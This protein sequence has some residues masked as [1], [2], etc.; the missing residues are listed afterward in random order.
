MS[1]TAALDLLKSGT[2]V[3]LVLTDHAM[4][5]MTGVDL[6]RHIRALRPEMAIIL[7]TGYAEL[8]ANADSSLLRLAKPY[9][10]EEMLAAIYRQMQ[11]SQPASN[12]VPFDAI[13][14]A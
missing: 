7:A 6:A 13:R 11:V 3:D 9:T 5:G 12:I 4:P 1:G 14:R 8:P 2:E 10:P